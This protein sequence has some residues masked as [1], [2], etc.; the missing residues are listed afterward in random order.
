MKKKTVLLALIFITK[1]ALA[2]EEIPIKKLIKEKQFLLTNYADFAKRKYA[3]TGASAF[4]ITYQDK[5]YAIT[6]KHLLGEAGGVKPEVKLKELDKVIEYWGLFP[7]VP[8]N[9]E[10]DTVYIDAKNIKYG[11]FDYDMLVLNVI[12]DNHKIDILNPS[13]ELPKKGEIF[14][15]IGCPYSEKDCKQNLYEIEFD[16]VVGELYYFN[17]K[18][19]INCSGFSGAPIVDKDGNVVSLLCGKGYGDAIYGVKIK[20]IQKIIK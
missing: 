1:V 9:E 20:E 5:T 18:T 4:L 6:A 3:L 8:V 7:R 15:I 13:F 2:Q 17:F 12:N 10:F 16:E 14:Y 19:D 11:D